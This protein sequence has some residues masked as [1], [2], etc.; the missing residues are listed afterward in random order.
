[1]K[2]RTSEKTVTFRR[3]FALAGLGEVLPAGTF[4]VEMDEELIEGVPYLAYRRL[5]TL[6]RPHPQSGHGHLTRALAVD[7]DELDA[8]L[9]RDRVTAEAPASAMKPR[10]DEIDRRAVERAEDEGMI[11][12]PV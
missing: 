8:A 3:P 9:A 7:P 6:L 1:M 2:T 11:A 4:S 10:Q 12:R 5:S